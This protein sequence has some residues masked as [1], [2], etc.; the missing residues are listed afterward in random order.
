[1]KDFIVLIA[2]ISLGIILFCILMLDDDSVKSA[3]KGLME[4]Q[5]GA[6]SD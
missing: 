3:S 4:S 6:L 1:M 5:L 2:L